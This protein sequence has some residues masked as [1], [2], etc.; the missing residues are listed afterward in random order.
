MDTA[1]PEMNGFRRR[2]QQ[3]LM[4]YLASMLSVASTTRSYFS[5]MLIAFSEVN[6]HIRLLKV[7]EELIRDMCWTADRALSTPVSASLWIIC[8]SK[9]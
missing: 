2:T 7:T 9:S 5:M 1:D 4:V 3:S 8:L 6:L